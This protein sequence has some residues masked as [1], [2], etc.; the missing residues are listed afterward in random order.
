MKDLTCEQSINIQSS[1]WVFKQ[2]TLTASAFQSFY[3]SCCRI[4]PLTFERLAEK[5]GNRFEITDQKSAVSLDTS[6]CQM[7]LLKQYL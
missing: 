6:N 1:Y 7:L 4:N 3:E 2:I 5:H